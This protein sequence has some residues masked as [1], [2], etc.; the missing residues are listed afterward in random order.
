[1]HRVLTTLACTLAILTAVL[2]T[3]RPALPSPASA[4]ASAPVSTQRTD[5]ATPA[6]GPTVRTHDGVLRGTAHDG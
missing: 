3:A 6:V 2:A 1:M 5:R 4:L